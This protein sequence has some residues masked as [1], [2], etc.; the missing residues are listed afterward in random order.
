[1]EPL[2]AKSSVGKPYETASVNMTVRRCHF[3]LA[4]RQQWIL[5][6]NSY[7]K[8]ELVRIYKKVKKGEPYVSLLSQK[9]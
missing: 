1:M 3:H 2:G 7:Q 9:S 5:L 6:P 4:Y 8:T